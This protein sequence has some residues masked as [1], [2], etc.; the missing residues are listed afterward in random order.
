MFTNHHYIL[1]DGYGGEVPSK[2]PM[3]HW[4]ISLVAYFSGMNEFAARAPSGI[5]AALFMGL[6]FGI[7]RRLRSDGFAWVATGMLFFSFEWLRAATTCG[8]V[9]LFYDARRERRHEV[10]DKGWLCGCCRCLPFQGARGGAAGYLSY[11]PL[12]V[13]QMATG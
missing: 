11:K 3:L 4:L 12:G 10:V 8:M 6:Y 13:F 2:P 1:P 9:M 7:L 5:F